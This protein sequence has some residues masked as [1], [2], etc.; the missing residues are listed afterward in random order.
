GEVVFTLPGHG[1]KN[2]GH[3]AVY[4]PDG[5]RIVG[6]DIDQSLKVWEAATGQ[7]ELTFRGHTGGIWG[8]AYSPDGRRMASA[9]LD[10]T[11]E[12]WDGAT[13]QEVLTLRG[14]TDGLFS[15]A[16]SPD[17]RRIASASFDQTVRIWDGTPVTPAWEAERL[18]LADQRWPVRQRREAE[19]C[20]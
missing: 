13:G 14:H 3:I 16:Y 9:S 1:A 18:A 17:G 4:S 20:E 7:E 10:R 15:V 5:R 19:D 8:G 2:L 11:V 6:M 12:G